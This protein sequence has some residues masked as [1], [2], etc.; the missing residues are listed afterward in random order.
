VLPKANAFVS[1]EW[2]T[3]KSFDTRERFIWGELY[4]PIMEKQIVREI[5]LDQQSFLETKGQ[6]VERDI[7]LSKTINSKE[8]VVISGI[9]RCGKSTLLRMISS[10]LDTRMVFID[11]SDI[12]FAN[13]SI[14]DYSLLDES[15][16]ELFGDVAVFLLDEVQNAPMWQR[17]VNNLFTSGKKVFLTG[18]NSNLLSSEISTYLTGR[19]RVIRLCP[20]SFREFLRLRGIHVENV[21]RLTSRE[22][23]LLRKS[24]DEYLKTGGFPEV[25]IQNDVGLARNYFEDIITKDIVARYGIRDVGELKEL[26]LY[27]VSNTGYS[28]SYNNLKNIVGIKSLSTIKS[29]LDH[30]EEAFLFQKINRFSYSI[31]K[32]RALPSKIYAGDVGFI[33]S[34]AFNFSENRGHRLE[35]LILNHLQRGGKEIYYHLEKKECD[36]IIKDGPKVIRAIQVSENLSNKLTMER[37]INGLL[38]ALRTYDLSEGTIITL[39]KQEEL[40]VEKYSINVIP[41]WKWLLEQ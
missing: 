18:S 9:R 16:L 40:K 38:D 19:N 21:N 30:L 31:K 1:K 25:L 39:D 6:L 35:N 32:Q 10:K 4:Y 13:F 37:E 3:S 29:F 33:T 5:L 2:N 34:T 12:R 27:L 24:F 15:I 14:E 7:D 23:S 11:F 36:F 8:I 41:A 26:A 22:K 20:F 28:V 17:W